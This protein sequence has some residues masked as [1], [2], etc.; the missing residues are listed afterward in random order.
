MAVSR[1]PNTRVW[2]QGSGWVEFVPT[3][4]IKADWVRP[5]QKVRSAS[6]DECVAI[7]D[8][9]LFRIQFND[10]WQALLS[11]YPLRK[12][13]G[14]PRKSNYQSTSLTYPKLLL[15]CYGIGLSL[16]FTNIYVSSG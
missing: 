4:R 2:V 3:V 6:V 5:E 13:W 1:Y 15:R 9:L 14:S 8:A 7:V 11:R 10:S 12:Q 16:K